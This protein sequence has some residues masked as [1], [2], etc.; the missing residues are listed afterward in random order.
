MNEGVSKIEICQ[1][2]GDWRTPD[3]STLYK[4]EVTLENGVIGTSY[5]KTPQPWYFTPG[6][7]VFYTSEGDKLKIR[8]VNA[9]ATTGPASAPAAQTYGDDSDRGKSIRTQW[10]IKTAAHSFEPLKWDSAHGT[11]MTYSKQVGTLAK[12][13]LSQYE[14]LKDL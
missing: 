5:A 14:E 3:G 4:L 8:R 6:T 1:R 7:D 11:I 9:D 10:A 2:A 12:M 13:Y